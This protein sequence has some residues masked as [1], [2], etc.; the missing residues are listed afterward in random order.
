VIRSH[1]L[2]G[3]AVGV[4]AVSWGAP[5]AR[6][7]DAAPMAVAMWRMV[8]AASLLLP[9]AVARGGWKGTQGHGGAIA[10]SAAL[11]GFHF[12]CWI[13]SLWLTTISA[14]VVLVST[15]PL[16]VLL[17]SPRLLATP[18]RRTN[19]ASFILALVGVAVI[20][21]G[22]FTVSPRA[23]VGDL[24][25]LGGAMAGAGYLVIGKRL[26][27]DVPLDRY[28]ALVYAGAALV[29]VGAVVALDSEPLPRD[30]ISWLPL[31]GMALGPTL[32]GHT[33]LNWALAHLEAYKVN[34]AA[35][36][37]PVLATLWG[38]LLLAESP[39][40]HVWPGGTLIIAALV[41]EYLPGGRQ[42]ATPVPTGRVLC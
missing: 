36:L 14:S 5:L 3:L 42:A 12:A 8:L 10:L 18:I 20:S 16:F 27:R 38:W 2:V 35:L 25:A 7:T 30:T 17:L 15:Q 6:M 11:L 22:D 29:L 23:F 34:L 26:R 21:W 37:E 28:L 1:A 19:L 31:L 41:L 13:P 32:T 4:V 33:L 9:F 39:P 40:L 24:L